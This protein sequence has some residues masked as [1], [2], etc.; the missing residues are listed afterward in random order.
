MLNEAHT[1]QLVA[2]QIIKKPN[3]LG[4][5]RP[6]QTPPPDA[7]IQVSVTSLH[8]AQ[9][10]TSLAGGA[11]AGAGLNPRKPRTCVS[12]HTQTTQTRRMD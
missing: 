7:E 12:S 11:A 5:H 6:S 8:Q 10:H 3:P 2:D 9:I 1:Q 4:I